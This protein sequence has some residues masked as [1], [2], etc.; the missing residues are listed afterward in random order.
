MVHAHG[1]EHEC[2]R[3]RQEHHYGK[4]RHIGLRI[5]AEHNAGG[6]PQQSSQHTNHVRAGEYARQ[7][8]ERQC[9]QRR[10]H[11]QYHRQS[12]GHMAERDQRGQHQHQ[13]PRRGR[14]RNAG[15]A[16]KHPWR[17]GGLHQ[18]SEA[19]TGG[20]QHIG[21]Q[22]S[23]GEYRTEHR[24]IHHH[25]GRKA[26]Q[27]H[28]HGCA[29]A[30]YGACPQMGTFQRTEQHSALLGLECIP[31]IMELLDL[32]TV[33]EQNLQGRCG[34]LRLS[35][36]QPARFHVSRDI[37]QSQPWQAQLHPCFIR[38]L[39]EHHGYGHAKTANQPPQPDDNPGRHGQ[40]SVQ[41]AL[42]GAM[43]RHRMIDRVIFLKR[44]PAS[45]TN[46]LIPC[47]TM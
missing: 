45:R 18:L 23:T 15:A 6:C 28:H 27:R 26:H 30:I 34:D 10:G 39:A 19:G 43:H 21:I 13:Q 12:G 4:H 16:A 44:L 22:R 37:G 40:V 31:T 41:I 7:R 35:G 42:L 2:E 9:A 32:P 1:T 33:G 24:P 20:K 5:P 3:G 29:P 46:A 36:H 14:R 47:A 25:D 38:L 11:K 8:P 17:G